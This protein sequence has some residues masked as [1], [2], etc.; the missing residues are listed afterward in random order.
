MGAT[1]AR[2][3][4]IGASMSLIAVG[5]L[6]LAGCSSSGGSQSGDHKATPPPPITEGEYFLHPSDVEVAGL[7][8]QRI[9]S[10]TGSAARWAYL[11]GEQPFNVLLAQTVG[12]Q[13]EAQAASQNAT[14]TPE[15]HDPNSQWLERGC[16][17][18]S[19]ALTAREIL[20]NPT[21]ALPVGE[22]ATLAIVCD[23]ILASGKNFGEMLRFIRGTS[24]TVVS[25]QVEIL[26][27]N[28]DSG[29]SARGRD[30]FPVASLPVLYDALLEVRGIEPPMSGD[31]VIPPSAATLADLGSSLSNVSFDTE[32]NT[33]V[34]IDQA[35]VAF[36]AA[37]D[38]DVELIPTTLVIPA[39]RADELLTPLGAG[40]STSMAAE[41]VWAGP[42]AVPS[43]REYVDC[44][45][46]PCVAVTYDDGP[47]SITTPQ[48]IDVYEARP[49]A[50]TT[51]FV[52]G[53]N[54]EGNEEVMKRAYDTGNE[55]ANHSWS[56][57]AF[58]TL[59]DATIA[60]QIN[61]TNAAITAVTGAPV[62]Q[63]RPPYGDL[64]DR[65]LAAAGMPAI[66]WSVDTNDWQQPGTDV[67]V[68]RA[69][70]GATPDGI[71]LMHDIHEATVAGA[72]SIA[73]GLLERGYT[74]VTV[75]QLFGNQD[76][77]AASFTSAEGVRS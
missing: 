53:Q 72:A 54:I 19:T 13:L 6:A 56:H 49:Y 25:D 22:D 64:N 76:M 47:S 28:T 65:T 42:T 17:Q 59:D 40:I 16:V 7:T 14:Y 60:A 44:N 5:A 68:Q 35:F 12:A 63:H 26:Y 70:D 57:P 38:P 18:G 43:G 8:G 51:F 23:P 11:P 67:V 3:A 31:E 61:D 30:L 46:V 1:H 4:K 73:D 32:G 15:A 45:L 41:E 55:I 39:Q 58:T 48:V 77:P 37:G 9:A 75:S 69:I 24:S 71:I 29:E 27:T 33:Y 74:L 20:D 52:L 36:I 10:S 62:T 66:L 34:T 50:A 2:V 21:L